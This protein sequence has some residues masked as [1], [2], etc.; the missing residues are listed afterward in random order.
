MILTLNWLSLSRPVK[1]KKGIEVVLGRLL[2]RKV[3]CACT[4]TG[5]MVWRQSFWKVSTIS[6]STS[7]VSKQQSSQSMFIWIISTTIISEHARSANKLPLLYQYLKTTEMLAQK[8]TTFGGALLK[9]RTVLN[10]TVNNRPFKGLYLHRGQTID[11]N[12]NMNGNSSC[13]KIAWIT[14]K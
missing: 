8:H 12:I 7:E 6:R 14:E 9:S 2:S 1:C 3:R 11:N 10:K 13:V 4:S 5:T